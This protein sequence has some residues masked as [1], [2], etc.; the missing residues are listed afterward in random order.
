LKYRFTKHFWDKWQERGD[1]FLE[2]GLSPER[3]VDFAFSPKRPEREWRVKKVED[4][5]LKIVVEAKRDTLIII[6]AYFDRTLRRKELC[7]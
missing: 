1:F 3:I 2:V 4:I 5:C 7:K 6:T